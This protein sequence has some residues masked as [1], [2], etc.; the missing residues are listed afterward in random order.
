MARI[1]ESWRETLAIDPQ[2]DGLAALAVAHI[3]EYEDLVGPNKRPLVEWLIGE[4][5]RATYRTM[6]RVYSASEYTSLYRDCLKEYLDVCKA[7]TRKNNSPDLWSNYFV[8]GMVLDYAGVLPEVDAC[9]VINLV[10]DAYEGNR[11]LSYL[12]VE[13]ALQQL[14]PSPLLP[15]AKI[16]NSIEDAAELIYSYRKEG[17]RT[18]G[19][20]GG[21]DYGTAGH[22]QV[23]NEASQIAGK[24][25][26]VFVFA[27]SDAELQ[28]TRGE[29]RPYSALDHRMRAVATHGFVN[30]VCA[31]PW[32]SDDIA[33]VNR[34][35]AVATLYEGLHQQL[36]LHIRYMGES[37]TRTP[38]FARQC[39]NADTILVY[40]ETPR[41]TRATELV[42]KSRAPQD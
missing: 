13:S 22:S 12:Q 38:E 29:G 16:L 41:L 27:A 35:Q 34:E 23:L 28:Q 19:V 31:L 26:K 1:L 15:G 21:W 14:E 5:V 40:G 37:D 18:V 2:R 10:L 3:P 30:H 24:H 7:K 32:I 42:K 20:M 33:E 25:G 4:K 36:R 39:L 8:L 6:S 11:S 17:I 9:F